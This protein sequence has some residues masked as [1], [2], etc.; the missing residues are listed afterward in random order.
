[1]KRIIAE[2][3]DWVESKGLWFGAVL[4]FAPP[5]WDVLIMGIRGFFEWRIAVTGIVLQLIG[6]ALMLSSGILR[7]LYRK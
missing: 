7:K 6:G 5:V 2:F 1:M 3:E 4:V